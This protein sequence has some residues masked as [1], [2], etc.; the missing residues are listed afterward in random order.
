MNDQEQLKQLI[1]EQI[2]SCRSYSRR[3]LISLWCDGGTHAKDVRKAINELI[4]EGKIVKGDYLDHLGNKTD[5]LIVVEA[6]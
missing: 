2:K 6:D 1:Y 5:D 4:D 3:K